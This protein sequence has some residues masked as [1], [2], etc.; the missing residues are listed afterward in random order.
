MDFFALVLYGM[1]LMLITGQEDLIAD[2]IYLT[3]SIITYMFQLS[4]V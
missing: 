1:S 4:C 3:A 2:K